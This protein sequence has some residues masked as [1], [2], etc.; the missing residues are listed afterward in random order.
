M[1]GRFQ[2]PIL[3]CRLFAVSARAMPTPPP[4][5]NPLLHI[6]GCPPACRQAGGGAAGQ[7]RGRASPSLSRRAIH[8]MSLGFPASETDSMVPR[9]QWWLTQ[10]SALYGPT[11]QRDELRQCEYTTRAHGGG[12]RIPGAAILGGFTAS[13][14]APA[15]AHP[16]HNP[17]RRRIQVVEMPT[18]VKSV[19]PVVLLGCGG[20]GRYLLRHIVSCRPLHANPVLLAP[21]PPLSVH[22]RA[23]SN[24]SVITDG[25]MVSVVSPPAYC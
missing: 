15:V 8:R 18:P 6:E 12:R 16:V 20:V 9:F 22:L 3:S 10:H 25:P 23:G 7:A 4:P 11:D 1:G 13:G 17:C 14:G 5:F 2:L 19:L 24:R 21:P